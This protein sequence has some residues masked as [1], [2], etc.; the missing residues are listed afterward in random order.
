MHQLGSSFTKLNEQYP[1]PR[2]RKHTCNT[3]KEKLGLSSR[4][5][6]KGYNQALQFG[7]SVT[8]LRDPEDSYDNSQCSPQQPNFH[9][10]VMLRTPTVPSKARTHVADGSVLALPSNCNLTR[11]MTHG[12]KPK[13]R[14]ARRRSTSS[15]HKF[16]THN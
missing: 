13:S 1:P 8:T 5:N 11:A 7:R 6:T 2:P 3:L 4:R 15:R 10:A 9:L 14:A 16:E 12:T